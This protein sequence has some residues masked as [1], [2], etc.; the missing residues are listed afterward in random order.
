MGKLESF[1]VM[2]EISVLKMHEESFGKMIVLPHY[3]SGLHR[4]EHL[5]RE[6]EEE[7]LEEYSHR[8]HTYLLAKVEDGKCMPFVWACLRLI[9]RIP[10]QSSILLF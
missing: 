6:E 10:Q 1:T 7:W 4:K 8:F 2:C 9:P 3:R 5:R